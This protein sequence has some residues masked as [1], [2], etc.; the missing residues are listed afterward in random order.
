MRIRTI[1]T[2]VVVATVL[3]LGVEFAGG[4]DYLSEFVN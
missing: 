2:I 1:V 4:F 3:V